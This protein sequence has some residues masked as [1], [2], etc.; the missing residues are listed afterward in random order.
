MGVMEEKDPRFRGIEKKV[1]IFIVVAVACIVIAII[2]IGLQ[3]EIFTSKA[4]LFF[5]AD[6]G[7]GLIKGQPVKFKGFR[8]GKV[9]DVILNKRGKVLIQITVL[10]DYLRF[11]KAD[12]IAI[13]KQEG[14]IGEAIISIT[15][16]SEGMAS[17]YDGGG[18]FF[19]RATSI[20][21]I[22]TE[23][24]D[25]AEEAFNEI[26]L[27]T[28]YLNDPDGDVKQ[29]IKNVRILTESFKETRKNI[30][31]LLLVLNKDLSTTLDNTNST[32]DSIQYEAVPQA[33]SL[34]NTSEATLIELKA[35]ID[36][37]L[38]KAD[39]SMDDVMEI[40]DEMKG[41]AKRVPFAVEEGMNLMQDTG[42]VL[43]AA[44]KTW[45]L[46]KHIEPEKG[47][48]IQVDSYE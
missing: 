42:E 4:S 18:I 46:N 32:L 13:H 25:K 22:A 35:Q 44:K 9:E 43:D 38:D 5:I 7:T 17:L 47:G 10:E 48:S 33:V 2:L 27:I 30:D 14:V 19:E 45:P 24:K 21:E 3:R 39:R 36:T 29:T 1:G 26:K 23:I 37:L 6:S 20:D 15:Q 28:N 12:S 8:I 16:G 40:L 41:T 34:M 11:I 31:K